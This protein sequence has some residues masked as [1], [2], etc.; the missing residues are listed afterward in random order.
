M[1]LDWNL[2]L[3]KFN[4]TIHPQTFS[5]FSDNLNKLKSHFAKFNTGGSFWHNRLGFSLAQQYQRISQDI[6][7]SKWADEGGHLF[8]PLEGLTEALL[9]D[10]SAV[11][12]PFTSPGLVDVVL[13]GYDSLMDGDFE[14]VALSVDPD[15]RV[16]L[17]FKFEVAEKI[18]LV[19]LSVL[20]QLTA[21]QAANLQWSLYVR[22]PSGNGWDLSD[23]AAISSNYDTIERRFSL[24]ISS[25]ESEI[26]VVAINNTGV[27]LEFTE[28]ESFGQ[29]TVVIRYSAAPAP[30]EKAALAWE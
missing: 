18:N 23:V 13:G 30:I 19:R 6:H 27:Q 9:T 15:Q 8:Y 29:H 2:I 16:A 12:D 20:T 14:N 26:M 4:Y 5:D 1:T 21:E 22:D 28:I 17:G 11:P 7:P 3:A 25:S 24:A 10:P